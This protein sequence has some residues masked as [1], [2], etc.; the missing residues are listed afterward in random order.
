[1]RYILKLI[2]LSWVTFTVLFLTGC[3]K[4][5]EMV[6]EDFTVID[7]LSD[8]VWLRDNDSTL[9]K[10]YLVTGYDK[11]SCDKKIFDSIVCDYFREKKES[12]KS[13]FVYFLKKTKN[14]N[15]EKMLESDRNFDRISMEEDFFLLY[16]MHIF[17]RRVY[18]EV[19]YKEY[20]YYYNL[21]YEPGFPQ[22]DKLTLE[23]TYPEPGITVKIP[24]DEVEPCFID[25]VKNAARKM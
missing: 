23:K 20:K 21:S 9:G 3:H 4:C 6:I 17:Q 19:S 11:Q 2:I 7:S 24:Q 15:N 12:Y 22:Y 13:M 5:G 16:E 1:M 25:L 18:M 10:Y 14:T 8:S